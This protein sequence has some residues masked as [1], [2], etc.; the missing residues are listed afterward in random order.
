MQL[1]RCYQAV[2]PI[3]SD[4]RLRARRHSSPALKG[5]G[6]LPLKGKTAAHNIALA[7]EPGLTETLFLTKQVPPVATETIPTLAP[8]QRMRYLINLGPVIYDLGDDIPLRYDITVSYIGGISPVLRSE[9]YVLDI[10][11]FR[12]ELDL[13]DEQAQAINQLGFQLYTSAEQTISALRAISAQ[14]AHGRTVQPTA[15]R[16]AHQTSSSFPPPESALEEVQSAAS[17]ASSREELPAAESPHARPSD[18]K[19]ATDQAEHRHDERAGRRR[20]D[21]RRRG[22]K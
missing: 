13:K 18:A 9:R 20:G 1:A 8:G 16:L 19:Q 11:S 4:A 15:E 14:L 2:S 22:S 7:F 3:S 10:N 12:A 5:R 6:L 21:H 17:A